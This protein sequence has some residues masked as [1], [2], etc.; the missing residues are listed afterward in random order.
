MLTRKAMC[1]L[2]KFDDTAHPENFILNTFQ[3]TQ[4]QDK[5]QPELSQPW[6][7]GCRFLLLLHR[8]RPGTG[9]GIFVGRCSLPE[10]VIPVWTKISILEHMEEYAQELSSTNPILSKMPPRC[11]V[12]WQWDLLLAGPNASSAS[13]SSAAPCRGREP[14]LLSD[15]RYP[16]HLQIPLGHENPVYPFTYH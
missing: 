7:Q 4:N 11:L 12:D 6:R 16:P 5:N 3:S 13:Q 15:T 10:K 9:R 1:K 8:W 2:S 14:A